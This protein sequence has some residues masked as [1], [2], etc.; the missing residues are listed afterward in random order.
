MVGNANTTASDPTVTR[1]TT[2]RLA[3]GGLIAFIAMWL[4]ITVRG[5][6][7][8]TEFDM[9]WADGI[10]ASRVSFATTIAHAFD[11]V[12]GPIVSGFV[13]PT[14][15]VVLLLVL[16]RR[17]AVVYLIVASVMSTVVV[18]IVKNIASRP[19]PDDILV[20]AD[21]GSFPSGHSANAAAIV[22]V[23]ALL[24]PSGRWIPVAGA[25]Y[26]T[27]MM[28]SRT[29]LSAHWITDTIAGAILGFSV[30]TGIWAAFERR[31][32]NE[33]RR[34]EVSPSVRAVTGRARDGSSATRGEDSRPERTDGPPRESAKSAYPSHGGSK[35][36]NPPSR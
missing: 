10:R 28:L 18:K 24:F 33:A 3:M 21:F 11:V 25:V 17:W 2:L 8:P 6:S 31:V 27:L 23:M 15:A 4:L 36:T 22:T 14:A 16:R 5:G 7:G 35:S 12:G 26:V 30:A 32:T 1:A 29:Y 9:W 19:R 13:I 20:T 34:D